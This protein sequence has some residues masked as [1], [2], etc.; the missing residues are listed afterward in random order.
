[1]L[2]AWGAPAPKTVSDLDD[3]ARVWTRGPPFDGLVLSAGV[4]APW[5]AAPLD[6]SS[7][8]ALESRLAQPPYAGLR[9]HLLATRMGPGTVT[10]EDEAGFLQVAANFGALAQAA[11]RLGAAGV[12][13]DTQTYDTQLFSFSAVGRGRAFDVVQASMRR[14]GEAVM[15]AMQAEHPEGLVVVT[16]GYAEV[17]RSVCLDGVALEADR[18]GLLPAFLDGLREGLGPERERQ[19]VDGFLPSYATKD[20]RGFSTLRA[21]I[22]FDEA[23][24]RTGDGAA[25]SYRFPRQSTE[26]DTFSWRTQEPFR[27]SEAVRAQ[28]TRTLSVGFGVMVDFQSEPFD[29]A[30]FTRNFHSPQGFVEVVRAAR[31][32]ADT[33][34]WLFSSQ[35]D[36]WD[37]PGWTP[38]PPEYRAAFSGP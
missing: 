2:L 32:E 18:Y 15:R 6:I 26:P 30:P 23:A 14:R 16:L 11:R 13:L 31:R 8:L 35:V 4:D 36:W 29:A 1:L 27:C 33:L 9:G 12:M 7:A 21:A 28:V 38:L 37:R 3:V 24:L 17:F 34:V 19:L 20:A 5:Q 22:A 25:V 10:D